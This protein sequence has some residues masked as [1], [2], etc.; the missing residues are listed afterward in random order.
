[1]IVLQIYKPDIAGSSDAICDYVFNETVLAFS[2][3]NAKSLGHMVSDFLN[4]W[5][6]MWLTGTSRFSKVSLSFLFS[7][8]LY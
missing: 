3:D 4:V 7:Y 6:M 8:F 2:H 1:M 5:T